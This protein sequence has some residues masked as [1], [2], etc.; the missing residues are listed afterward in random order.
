ME[1]YA[2]NSAKSKQ[3]KES[4]TEEVQDKKV[5]SG[6]ARIAKPNGAKKFAEMFIAED[7]KSVKDY[8]LIDVLAP[9]IKKA[10][11]DIVTNGINMI[12][13]GD[14]KGNGGNRNNGVKTSYRSYYEDSNST[15]YRTARSFSF[16]TV[17]FE[18]RSDADDVLDKMI[19]SINRYG[20][21][22]VADM[23]EFAG[24]AR[25]YTDNKYGWRDL[26]Q[27]Y[28]EPDRN[29]G[30]YIKLPRAIPLT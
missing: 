20:Q 17:I 16:D 5:I 6:N 10:V 18:T 28:T 15:S 9:A 3:A 27:A 25:N 7:V 12:L 1:D 2:S 23:Y 22:S 24:T 4:E 26:R 19:E 11:S 21:V 8:I 30:Y 13:Y 29:G 14:T